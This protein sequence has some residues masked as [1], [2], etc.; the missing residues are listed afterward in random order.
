ML[1]VTHIVTK[2]GKG[3][4]SAPPSSVED[5]ANPNR[6]GIGIWYVLL[7]QGMAAK[8]SDDQRYFI[9]M[10]KNIVKKMRCPICREHAV[11]YVEDNPP[12]KYMNITLPS[13]ENIGMFKYVWMFK[14]EVNKRLGKKEM[15]WDTAYSLYS[16]DAPVCTEVCTKLS[17][18]IST[19]ST[20]TST[21][22]TH[23]VHTSTSTSIPDMRHS[24]RAI[25]SFSREPGS[26]HGT[27]LTGG[28]GTLSGSMNRTGSASEAATSRVV[29]GYLFDSRT[30]PILPL[31]SS[32]DSSVTR[33]GTSQT[34]MRLPSGITLRPLSIY[35]GISSGTGDSAITRI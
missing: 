24:T 14:N 22:V 18:G 7:E 4:T 13:G 3:S 28:R 21:T 11:K 15:D 19:T 25:H 12:E 31:S 32:T 16:S 6:V 1:H 10:L 2:D 23:T 26:S 33:V 17:H 35:N 30:I 9:K 5:I 29:P 8:D 20:T 34:E 27:S